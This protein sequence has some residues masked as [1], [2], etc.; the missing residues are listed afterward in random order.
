MRLDRFITEC[1]PLTR[2]EAKDA[3]KSGRVTFEG[4]PLKDGSLH[5]KEEEAEIFLDGKKLE[6]RKFVY[7]LL[8]KPLGVVTATEDRHQTTVMDLM[9][10]AAGKDLFPVGRLDKNTDGLLLIT[11]DGKLGHDLLAPGKHVPKSY[12]ATL[13]ETL[14]E[15]DRKRL[16]EG[17]DIGD[18]KLTLPAVCEILGPKE[19]K[20]TVTEGRYHQVRRMLEAV[21]NEVITLRRISFGSLKLD[22]T[23]EPGTFRPLTESELAA[24][25]SREG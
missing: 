20:L 21:E 10:G 13:R 14:S 15:E 17:V 24:L 8:Y 18:D 4:K 23:M 22:E 2:K 7:Y 25:R 9:Q 3:L 6:Y 1:L 5:V 16:E 12:V 19:I 11:N